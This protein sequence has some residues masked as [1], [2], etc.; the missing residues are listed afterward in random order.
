MIHSEFEKLHDKL[1]EYIFHQIRQALKEVGGEL[2]NGNF[3]CYI[4]VCDMDDFE[5]RLEKVTKITLNCEEK[6]ILHAEDGT[7][8]VEGEW[9]F[10]DITDL[11]VALQQYEDEYKDFDCREG[12]KPSFMEA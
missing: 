9:D 12:F 4:I 6:V 7:E 5:P 11:E 10:R 8:F 2:G 3:T 1:N